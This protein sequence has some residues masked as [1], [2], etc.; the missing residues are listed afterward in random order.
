LGKAFGLD[1]GLRY[2][3]RL[4]GLSN[5]DQ[6]ILGASAYF[7]WDVQE[8]LSAWAGLA[9]ARV[10]AG[11]VRELGMQFTETGRP[12][13]SV[14]LIREDDWK[15]SWTLPLALRYSL[16]ETFDV[17]LFLTPRFFPQ[18]DALFGAGVLIRI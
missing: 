4:S 9:W 1:L 6:E 13:L 5:D 17:D 15:Q 8:R 3:S 2:R 16:T 11:E 10:L 14:F 7:I 12:G 18:F